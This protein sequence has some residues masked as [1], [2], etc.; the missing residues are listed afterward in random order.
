MKLFDTDYGIKGIKIFIDDEIYHI[1][2][3][4]K[5]LSVEM[6]DIFKIVEGE[7][8]PTRFKQEQIMDFTISNIAKSII[9]DIYR[10]FKIFF[11]KT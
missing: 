10:L 5:G 9:F 2:V 1:Y 6:V 11:S 8:I 4:K 3:R 7:S